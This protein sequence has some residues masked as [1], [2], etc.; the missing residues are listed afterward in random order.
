APF[1]RRGPA[2]RATRTSCPCPDPRPST[3]SHVL[4]RAT[5]TVSARAVVYDPADGAEAA[6]AMIVT[7]PKR[8]PLRAHS[9]AARREP[10]LSPPGS[11]QRTGWPV[12][13]KLATLT[14]QSGSP[15]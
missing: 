10:A 6:R 2:S 11:R 5:L 1:G 9:P 3:P 14:G 4:L 8:D 13:R 15:W 12:R 7:T